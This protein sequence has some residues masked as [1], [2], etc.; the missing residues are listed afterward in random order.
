MDFK[1]IYQI[2]IANQTETEFYARVNN[3]PEEHIYICANIIVAQ[4]KKCPK[5]KEAIFDCLIDRFGTMILTKAD[6]G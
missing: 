1:T 5:F 6:N 3:L 4:M 2:E